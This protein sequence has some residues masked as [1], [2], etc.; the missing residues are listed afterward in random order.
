MTETTTG[1]GWDEQIREEKLRTEQEAEAAFEARIQ[2]Y[3]FDGSAR[4]E[5]ERRR[6][7]DK[8]RRFERALTGD[9]DDL[10]DEV[11]FTTYTADDIREQPMLPDMI[12]GLLGYQGTL[13]MVSG[14]RG[15]MKSLAA[16]SIAGAV[17]T[18]QR[19]LW[20]L[21]VNVHGPVLYVYREGQQGLARR[22]V[23]W[24]D[25]Y[26]TRLDNVT[27]VHDAVNL[28]EPEDVRRLALLTRSLG[29][30]LV[31]LDPVARTG[32][33]KEDVEDFGN[34]RLGVEALRDHTGAS[35]LLTHNAGHAQGNR[36]RG[37]ST[38]EDGMDSCVSFA[39]QTDAQGGGVLLEDTKSRDGAPLPSIRLTFQPCGPVNPRTGE[40]WS[41][42]PV[43]QD[44]MD[45]VST[46]AAAKNAEFERVLRPLRQAGGE[47]TPAELAGV[48]G[49]S[50]SNL[51]RHRLVKGMI[52]AGALI[53]NG[54]AGSKVRYRVGAGW[55]SDPDTSTDTSTGA[56]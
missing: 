46:A 8:A 43:V 12:D 31:I 29:A 13:N 21:P 3:Y 45:T 39:A 54:E 14:R 26:G 10:A 5:A 19:A 2:E 55:T 18:G 49:V 47:M 30:V 9:L 33:G 48:L 15:S 27:F 20:G 41:G 51:S 25:H 7:R 52:T 22:L 11:P 36:G 16:I 24:E 34:Y 56:A 6:N 50:R 53:H 35:V 1:T 28:R 38:L 42:V 32:G 37:H 44:P 4:E 40:H 17:A 23:A